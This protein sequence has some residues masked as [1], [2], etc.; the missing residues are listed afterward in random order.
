VT[1]G[2]D[3]ALVRLLNFSCR[4]GVVFLL[5]H[6]GLTVVANNNSRCRWS[7]YT[8]YLGN[9]SRNCQKGSYITKDQNRLKAN[10]IGKSKL[11][12]NSQSLNRTNKVCFREELRLGI[13]GSENS[14]LQRVHSQNHLSSG[15]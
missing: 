9:L 4:T 2:Q 3:V 6:C 8:R 10:I 1:D 13:L 7:K 15:F 14:L 5:R 12:V 11:L